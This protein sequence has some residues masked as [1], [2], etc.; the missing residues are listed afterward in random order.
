MSVNYND[1]EKLFVLQTK[2]TTYAFSVYEETPQYAGSTERR[3]LR[4]LYWGK[5][6]ERAEDHIRPVNWYINGYNDGGKHSHERYFSEYVGAGGMFY[7]EP[8]L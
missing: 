8:T 2:R 5:K 6:I 3:T 7:S 4:S 1:S